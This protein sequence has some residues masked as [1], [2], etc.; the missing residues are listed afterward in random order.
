LQV[1]KEI[2]DKYKGWDADGPLSLRGLRL[3]SLIKKGLVPADVEP[4]PLHVL[5]AKPFTDLA[6]E[7]RKRSSRAVKTFAAMVDL[8]DVNLGRV[9]RY[10]EQL[11]SWT[12]HSSSTCPIT[13]PKA[14]YSKLA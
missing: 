9:M 12:T 6:E 14:N 8:I 11:A 7:V 4:A 2:R 10:L 1:H 3:K 13:A 5:S